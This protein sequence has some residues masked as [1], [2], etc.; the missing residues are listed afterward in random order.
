MRWKMRL[1]CAAEV[2][3]YAVWTLWQ[4][5]KWLQRRSDKIINLINLI[6]KWSRIFIVGIFWQSQNSSSFVWNKLSIAIRHIDLA[7]M[8][9]ES[10]CQSCF[11]Q[12]LWKCALI[13]LSYFSHS[14]AEITWWICLFVIRILLGKLLT[15]YKDV[16]IGLFVRSGLRKTIF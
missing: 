10:W 9:L 15:N 6:E 12:F 1:S 14:S 2:Y 5:L 11:Q 16:V 4:L 3:F 13:S 8:S 7:E